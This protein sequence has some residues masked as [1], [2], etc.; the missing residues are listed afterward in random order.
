MKFDNT[1]WIFVDYI[2]LHLGQNIGQN[3][4]QWQQENLSEENQNEFI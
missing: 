4:V 3:S 1:L 2:Y